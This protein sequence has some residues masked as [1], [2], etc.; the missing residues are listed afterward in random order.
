V[1]EH[2]LLS[3]AVYHVIC[4]ETA[5][6]LLHYGVEHHLKQ[7]I[8]Q[9]LA[10]TGDVIPVNG[11]QRLVGLLQKIPADGLM[12]LLAVPRTAL[13]GTQQVHDGE[14]ILPPIALFLLKIYHISTAF[15]SYFILK[16]LILQDF[17]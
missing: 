17:L 4:G 14:K 3:H 1:A 10:H 12:G 9:F 5:L 8:P 16:T 11:V 13:G 6:F 2:Q 7:N 15:A